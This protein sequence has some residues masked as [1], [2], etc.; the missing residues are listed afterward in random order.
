MSEML[1]VKASDPAVR[2]PL[3][4]FSG[5]VEGDAVV[6]VPDHAYYRRAIGDGDLELVADDPVVESV[7]EPVEVAVSKPSKT[8]KAKGE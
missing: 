2:V 1:K 3:M 6:Q 8:S 7:V 5:Y 4:D